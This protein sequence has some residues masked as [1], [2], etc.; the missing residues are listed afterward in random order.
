[1]SDI[2][3]PVS[4]VSTSRTAVARTDVQSGSFDHLRPYQPS[5]P[6]VGR[7]GETPLRARSD[8]T[9]ISD[10]IAP[11]RET[12][13]WLGSPAISGALAAVS[14]ELAPDG[15]AGSSRD[16]YVASVVETHLSARRQLAHH[17]NAL[18]RA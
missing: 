12:A 6:S 11:S 18:L 2:K 13:Q 1:M 17:L 10:F 14:K 16:Q 4:R 15:V 8:D 7:D 9:A 3:S 5:A